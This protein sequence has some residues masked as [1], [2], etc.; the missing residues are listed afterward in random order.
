MKTS[1]IVFSLII[2]LGCVFWI[3][4]EI[5]K[6]KEID[7]KY[8]QRVINYQNEQ[9]ATTANMRATFKRKGWPGFD[10]YLRMY[11]IGLMSIAGDKHFYVYK[12]MRYGGL[13]VH[14]GEVCCGTDMRVELR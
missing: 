3:S 11:G 13:F 6:T 2:I 12:H 1:N 7:N 10:D 14:M 4:D 5:K 9:A 8:T